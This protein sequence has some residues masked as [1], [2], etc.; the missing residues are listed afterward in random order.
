MVEPPNTEIGFFSL[1]FN[2]GI[3][4]SFFV[5]ADR[6]FEGIIAA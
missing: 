4:M 1:I 6:P 3:N 2:S 5:I